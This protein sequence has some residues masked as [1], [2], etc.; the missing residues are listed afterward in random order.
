MTKKVRTLAVR[1]TEE[2]DNEIRHDAVEKR[3]TLREMLEAYQEAYKK[4]MNSKF[5]KKE[6]GKL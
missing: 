4:L 3:C 6:A 2:F 5:G 1:V